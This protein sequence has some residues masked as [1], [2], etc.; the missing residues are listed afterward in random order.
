MFNLSAAAPGTIVLFDSA[1]EGGKRMV[2]TLIPG[3]VNE[4]GV[5]T[6][7]LWTD[8][9]GGTWPLQVIENGNP[10]VIVRPVGFD[11]AHPVPGLIVTFD[12]PH[13]DDHPLVATFAPGRLG[14]NGEFLDV[15]WVD[16]AGRRW[17]YEVILQNNPR[18]FGDAVNQ[19]TNLAELRVLLEAH[20]MASA[21]SIN[22]AANGEAYYLEQ[23]DGQ[24]TSYYLERGR[25]HTVHEFDSESQACSYFWD[26][27]QNERGVRTSTDS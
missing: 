21:Y 16:S 9:H 15:S 27:L 26:W 11:L 10:F 14:Q 23:R 6:D 13:G 18:V 5:L 17:A 25:R 19:P 3:V 1:D 24:W 22:G 7:L 2:A 4:N 20:I 12:N 8:S